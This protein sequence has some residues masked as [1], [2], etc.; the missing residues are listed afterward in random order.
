MPRVLLRLWD[1]FKHETPDTAQESIE[2]CSN[3]EMSFILQNTL[4]A[5][6]L[7]CGLIDWGLDLV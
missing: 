5:T 2:D 3:Q 7:L 1:I 4:E 6:G